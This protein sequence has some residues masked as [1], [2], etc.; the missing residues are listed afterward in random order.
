MRRFPPPTRAPPFDHRP[1]LPHIIRRGETDI[2]ITRALVPRSGRPRRYFAKDDLLWAG[3]ILLLEAPP[4]RIKEIQTSLGI[5]LDLAA[6][7]KLIQ[8]REDAARFE[9]YV[10]SLRELLGP[11][12]EQI[13]TALPRRLALGFTDE[14][15]GFVRKSFD[16][17]PGDEYSGYHIGKGGTKLKAN[18][19]AYLR[20]LPFGDEGDQPMYP[21]SFQIDCF[22]TE[23]GR[24]KEIFSSFNHSQIVSAHVSFTNFGDSLIPWGNFGPLR[25]LRL[26][27]CFIGTE[28]L[29]PLCDVL[30]GCKNTLRSFD[31]SGNFFFSVSEGPSEHEKFF[32]VLSDCV[33]L[34]K[35][36]L[37]DNGGIS[38]GFFESGLVEKFFGALGKLKKL[39]TLN[40]AY[41]ISPEIGASSNQQIFSDL[42]SAIPKSVLNFNYS[43]N[44]VWPLDKTH[45]GGPLV[46]S[47]DKFLAWKELLRRL[48]TLSLRHCV[49]EH[50]AWDQL[51]SSLIGWVGLH[52]DLSHMRCSDRLKTSLSLIMDTFNDSAE[53]IMKIRT[54]KVDFNSADG[55]HD[56]QRA[57]LRTVT[58]PGLPYLRHFNVLFSNPR[59]SE[60][61]LRAIHQLRERHKEAV[62]RILALCF[63]HRESEKRL[64][65]P[66]VSPTDHP[67]AMLPQD[68]LGA[69][70][71]C[72]LD[73]KCDDIRPP[74][75]AR[76]FN[77][78][79]DQTWFE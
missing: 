74:T 9:S 10:T 19:M 76:T 68:V 75:L 35:L 22:G 5:D 20:P 33:I 3:A 70:Q 36:N 1:S 27:C 12:F 52:L 14:Q 46:G 79:M 51:R 31:I 50:D 60:N 66:S 18:I 71:F 17:S 47:K 38:A 40:L 56:H 39:H 59:P 25:S 58:R 15:T 45:D 37:D 16:A 78:E 21:T 41:F 63:V 43:H 2:P 32:S 30:E 73:S 23:I 64:C 53:H 13:Q 62:M 77:S 54:V 72:V 4:E 29:A 61:F 49:L 65:D 26:P 48:E 67:L 6:A 44:T 8:E 69:I 24:V 42:I 57:I 55:A 34:E 7:R 11:I 28:A